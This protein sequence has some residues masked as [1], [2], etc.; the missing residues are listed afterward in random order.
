ME[1]AVVVLGHLD[2]AVHGEP[3][4]MY[5]GD[6]HKD[7]H[8]QSAVVEIFVFLYFL[9]N[10]HLAVSSGHDRI[11]RIAV[12]ESDGAAEEVDDNQRENRC[13]A[14]HDIERQEATIL[15]QKEQQAIE[16]GV[17]CQCEEKRIS[18]LAV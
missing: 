12:E 15:Q 3:V 16:Y 4:G 14:A 11:F 7:G 2:V 17:A 9:H 18:A 10:D 8:H 5:V 13:D 1:I 6:A